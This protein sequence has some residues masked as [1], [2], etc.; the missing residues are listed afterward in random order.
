MK[1]NNIFK[2]FLLLIML[3]PIS[4]IA[5]GSD[6]DKNDSKKTGDYV[7]CW[8]DKIYYYYNRTTNEFK[9]GM[10]ESSG[11]HVFS[12]TL[13]KSNFINSENKLYCPTIYTVTTTTNSRQATTTAY[14]KKPNSGTSFEVKPT[15]ENIHADTTSSQ[16]RETCVYS[17]SSNKIEFILDTGTKT[18]ISAQINSK[19]VASNAFSYDDIWKD[20]KCVD[21][22]N[23]YASCYDGSRGGPAVCNIVKENPYTGTGSSSSSTT[24]DND[25]S[26]GG[27]KDNVPDDNY[28][29]GTEV[30]GCDVVPKEIRNWIRIAL[31][32]VKYI[33]LVLVI[34]LG[35]IDFIK[36][37]GSG[38]PDAMKKAGQTFIKRVVAVI[39]LFLL[40]MIVELILNLI[41]LY[42]STNDCFGVLK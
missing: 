10:S 37:A 12:N 24:I 34:V 17:S 5:G 21:I 29:P 41:N 26:T 3:I 22:K 8:Y 28:N 14:I 1:R 7:E 20:N 30:T 2:L 9:S 18:I 11:Y 6:D 16:N 23:I 36:A 42:G 39:I 4:V 27:N 32:F 35:T 25:A 38:E 19:D 40:P 13:I 33:A 15:K 31:N